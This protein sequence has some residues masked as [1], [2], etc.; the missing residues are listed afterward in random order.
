M[1]FER[2][3]RR[4]IWLVCKFC[5]TVGS[6]SVHRRRKLLNRTHSPRAMPGFWPS[7]APSN[8]KLLTL[9]STISESRSA[10]RM[11]VRAFVAR[12]A[13]NPAA[14]S[15]TRTSYSGC[16]STRCISRLNWSLVCRRIEHFQP[17]SRK[18]LARPQPPGTPLRGQGVHSPLRT[19]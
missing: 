16:T 12:N 14:L 7:T 3:L 1:L 17:H 9:D 15:V 10:S 19:V 11:S 18:H 8:S 4:K 13:A 5:G 6:F 2:P